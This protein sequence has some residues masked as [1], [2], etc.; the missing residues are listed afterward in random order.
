MAAARIANYHAGVVPFV[1]AQTPDEMLEL[2]KELGDQLK[3]P[4]T[5]RKAIV[6]IGSPSV[7]NVEPRT[8]S[9][10]RQGYPDWVNALTTLAVNHA[11][12]YSMIPAKLNLL[13]GT[14]VDAS[15]GTTFNASG[16]F[17]ASAQ[18]VWR[19]LGSYYLVSYTPPE[20]NKDLRKITVRTSRKGAVVRARAIRG[21]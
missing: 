6:C 8:Q 19:E 16:D 11:S 2:V 12:V 5:G 9:S 18:Q 7:C 1:G 17:A 21:K 13:N 20:S 14:L 15:G 4:A 3:E 10:P